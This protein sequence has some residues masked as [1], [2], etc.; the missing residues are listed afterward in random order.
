MIA[1]VKYLEWRARSRWGFGCGRFGNEELVLECFR[2][3]WLRSAHSPDSLSGIPTWVSSFFLDSSKLFQFE[4]FSVDSI[5]LSKP[6]VFHD[7]AH[8]DT[9]SDTSSLL[10]LQQKPRTAQKW[11]K[12]K[13][14]IV[15]FV[16]SDFA[17][18]LTSPPPF[19]LSVFF[20]RIRM[21]DYN[22]Q[23]SRESKSGIDGNG[24]NQSEWKP[25][26]VTWK[27]PNV[28]QI[29]L[30]FLFIKS[31]HF[32]GKTQVW[33]LEN[34]VYC[35]NRLAYCS[36]FFW[37][38]RAKGNGRLEWVDWM[39]AW[40]RVTIRLD[41]EHDHTFM[42]MMLTHEI[43]AS[44]TFMTFSLVMSNQV[45]TSRAHIVKSIQHVSVLDLTT[46]SSHR[47]HATARRF[48][49]VWLRLRNFPRCA[50]L[51]CRRLHNLLCLRART[52]PT[53][54]NQRL[55]G[56]K[57]ITALYGLLGRFRIFDRFAPQLA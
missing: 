33:V 19:R 36:L 21:C 44:I 34:H 2:R 4:I 23:S 26:Y 16:R 49:F 27:R 40:W 17:F 1:V 51:V 32:C 9:P 50:N 31:A 7:P 42:L 55:V 37:F 35:A 57:F 56:A 47:A 15:F 14:A 5:W 13:F 8:T 29:F 25:L 18:S 20:C 12:R 3:S 30:A 38:H 45:D 28:C 11:I 53:A 46:M 10:T 39:V 54:S 48:S 24:E 52:A 43:P 6:K 22:K 41:V